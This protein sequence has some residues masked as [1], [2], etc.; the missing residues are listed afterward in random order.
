VQHHVREGSI[1]LAVGERQRARLA[2]AQLDAEL[3]LGRQLGAR[4]VEHA[5]RVVDRDHAQPQARQLGGQDSGAG[6]DVG[7][8]HPRRL[9]ARARGRAARRR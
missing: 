9:N 5:R 7:D 6:A 2:A 1:H 8:A 3:A 4:R